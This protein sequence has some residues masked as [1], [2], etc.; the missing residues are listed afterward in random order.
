MA[1]NMADTMENKMA[2]K[3]AD[4]NDDGQYG[5]QD[6]RKWLLESIS[7]ILQFSQCDRRENS[8]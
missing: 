2:N 7:I 1:G 6:G 4:K 5:E 8:V 3:M